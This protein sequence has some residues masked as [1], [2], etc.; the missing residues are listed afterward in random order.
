MRGKSLGGGMV[1]GKVGLL[2]KPKRRKEMG[3]EG[4][5][6]KWGMRWGRGESDLKMGHV[7]PLNECARSHLS[8]GVH[9]VCEMGLCARA[10]VGKL[11]RKPVSA[12]EL[13]GVR[14]IAEC[15]NFKQKQK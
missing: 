9:S 4:S 15:R 12:I 2:K 11:K 5:Q 13:T 6:H 1:G 3:R 10:N 8:R 7:R 14:S